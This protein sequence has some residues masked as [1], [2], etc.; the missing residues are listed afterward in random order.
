[1]ISDFVFYDF[2]LIVYEI[3]LHMISYKYEFIG[4]NL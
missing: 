2:I 4:F 3:I 1:M